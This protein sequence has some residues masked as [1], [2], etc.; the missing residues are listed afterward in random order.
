[1]NNSETIAKL[2]DALA[3]LIKAYEKLQDENT[4]LNNQIEKLTLE[5]N[6]LLKE[7]ENLEEDI[8]SFQS[9]SKEQNT[10]INSMLGKIE[11]LLGGDSLSSSSMKEEKEE[12]SATV[13]TG[14]LDTNTSI[15]D[16]FATAPKKEGSE[17]EGKLD[18]NRM[19]SLLNGF[20]N[21]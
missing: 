12:V 13:V 10:N 7:K 16:E 9:N 17:E 21:K 14:P 5:K 3:K 4:V 18:L 11:S 20:G 19:A 1:M 2:N 15:E 6:S 8:N